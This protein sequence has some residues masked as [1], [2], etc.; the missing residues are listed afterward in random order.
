MTWIDVSV[1]IRTGMAVYEGDPPVTLERT[2]SMDAGSLCN[3]SRLDFGVHT[4]THIDAPVHFLEGGPARVNS[5]RRAARALLH[6]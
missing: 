2:A 1:P 5:A 3:V 4:G 6:C